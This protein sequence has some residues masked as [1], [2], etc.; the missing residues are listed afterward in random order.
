MEKKGTTSDNGFLEHHR[1]VES[2]QAD[3]ASGMLKPGQRL[4]ESHLCERFGTKRTRIREVLR[5]LE[6]DGFVRIIPN[7]GATVAP[8]TQKEIEH[9]YDL[10]GVLEGLAVRVITPFVSAQQ[11]ERLEVLVNTMEVTD[12]PLLFLEYNHEFHFVLT[13]LSEN[14]RLIKFTDILRRNQKRYATHSFLSPGQIQESR[15][16]H[17]KILQAMKQG[18]SVE[19][20]RLMRSHL[21]RAKNRLIKYMNK[22]L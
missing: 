20:E 6:R 7:V 2:L 22:S 8:L 13:S 10:L 15:I 9:T 18:R 11:L 19:A 1:I 21:L 16:D 5:Q 12:T 3:V 14:D 17:R 4:V